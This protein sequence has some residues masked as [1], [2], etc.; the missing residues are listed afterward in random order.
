MCDTKEKICCFYVSK[1]HLVTMLI[2]YICNCLNNG[3]NIETFFEENLVEIINKINLNNL[4]KKKILE[5]VDW[6]KLNRE[7]LSKK[8]ESENNI[9]IVAGKNDFIERLN[10]IIIN[11]HTNFTLVNCYELSEIEKM[12]VQKINKYDKILS[13]K[14]IAR[15]EEIFTI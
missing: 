2:P 8:F 15:V 3:N 12:D 4:H 1:E 7:E 6:K 9:I 10:N 14:G 13:T 11:F 5:S